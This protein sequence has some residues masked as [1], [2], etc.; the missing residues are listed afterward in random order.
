MEQIAGG[1]MV[2]CENS[3]GH[4]AGA[5]AQHSFAASCG[6]TEVVPLL[7]SVAR[8]NFRS[9]QRPQILKKS[10]LRLLCQIWLSANAGGCGC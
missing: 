6:P 3:Q 2:E 7:Q 10:R 9:L 4:P 5:E 1:E 8:L